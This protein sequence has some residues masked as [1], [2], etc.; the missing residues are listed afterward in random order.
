MLQLSRVAFKALLLTK[1]RSRE[2]HSQASTDISDPR[3]PRQLIHL[4]RL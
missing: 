2:N 3:L 1:F 4:I